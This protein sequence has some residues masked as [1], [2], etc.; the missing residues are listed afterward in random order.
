M[1][2]VSFISTHQLRKEF[3]EI[4]KENRFSNPSLVLKYLSEKEKSVLITDNI[5]IF[6]LLGDKDLELID[7]SLLGSIPNRFKTCNTYLFLTNYNKTEIFQY[8]FP[9]I[10]KKLQMM[11]KDKI[12]EFG[13]DDSLFKIK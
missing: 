4:E 11:K 2:V 7:L 1:L 5:L 6:Q 10:F 12:L 8:R 9:N 13:N 3:S